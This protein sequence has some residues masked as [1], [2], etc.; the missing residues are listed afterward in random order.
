LLHVV[1]YVSGVLLVFPAQIYVLS[2]LARMGEASPE[3]A[4]GRFA[5]WLVLAGLIFLPPAGMALFGVRYVAWK[6]RPLTDDLEDLAPGITDRGL[7]VAYSKLEECGLV[8]AL[9]LE[10]IGW[11][12]ADGRYGWKPRPYGKVPWRQS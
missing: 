9:V 1:G 4:P 6:L 2:I 11:R 3:I 5:Q 8:R 7:N 10:G 12:K